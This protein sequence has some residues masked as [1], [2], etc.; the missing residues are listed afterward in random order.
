MM[1]G[2]FWVAGDDGRRLAVVARPRGLEDLVAMKRVGVD[3]L[4]SLLADEEAEVV[5]LAGERSLCRN[6]G[7]EFL[8]LPIVDHG[9]PAT[10]E[11]VSALTE[12]LGKCL[13]AGL[14]VA[15]HCR[16]GPARRCLSQPF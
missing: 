8:R 1:R 12:V 7:V 2:A 14:A 16:V 10:I 3:V 13:A 11:E 15:V 6:A 9:I 5:G 4:V